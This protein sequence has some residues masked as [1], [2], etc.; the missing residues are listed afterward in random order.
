MRVTAHKLS[1]ESGVKQRR[2]TVDYARSIAGG[3][4]YKYALR[5][6]TRVYLHAPAKPDVA[7]ATRT[8]PLGMEAAANADGALGRGFVAP[9]LPRRP[10]HLPPRKVAALPQV[11]Y[12]P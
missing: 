12:A 6:I 4:V 8:R 5:T 11:P 7:H 9:D 3:M 2:Y 10:H 1:S